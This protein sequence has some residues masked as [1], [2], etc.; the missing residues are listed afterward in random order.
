MTA[1]KYDPEVVLDIAAA[2]ESDK[3]QPIGLI[4]AQL[5]HL[6]LVLLQGLQHQGREP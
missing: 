3:H 2:A 1:S 5:L 6:L 4:N